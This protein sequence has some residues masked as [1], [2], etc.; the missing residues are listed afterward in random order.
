MA[1]LTAQILL[2][3]ITNVQ[4]SAMSLLFASDSDIPVQES[5]PVLVI[6][7][8]QEKG[9]GSGGGGG[10][11]V[12]AAAAAVVS[13]RVGVLCAQGHDVRAGHVGGKAG[14][15]LRH[16]VGFLCWPPSV[17]REIKERPELLLFLLLRHFLARSH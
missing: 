15:G 2:A 13:P 9:R 3:L 10:D 1:E 5:A 4:L 14:V 11:A 17:R 12:A 6:R 16:E 7:D 8:A